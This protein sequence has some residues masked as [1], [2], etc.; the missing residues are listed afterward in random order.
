MKEQFCSK[1]QRPWKWIRMRL[2]EKEVA[3]VQVPS[4]GVS[5]AISAIFHFGK[6]RRL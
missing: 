6:Y 2:Q 5:V 1:S 4:S 3:R